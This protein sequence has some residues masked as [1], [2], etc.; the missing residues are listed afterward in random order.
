MSEQIGLFTPAI[1]HKQQALDAIKQFSFPEAK[2][3]LEIAKEIDPYL[4]DLNTLARAVDFLLNL[5]IHQE[6]EPTGLAQAW[7][8]V[9]N[10]RTTQARA[11]NNIMESWLCE[12]IVE[13][14]PQDFCDYVD[15]KQSTLH[16]G[17][18]YLILN[19][20]EEAHK[21]LLNYLT[22]R[23]DEIH[24]RLWGYYGDAAY[25]LNS[26]KDSNSG[27]LRALFMDVQSVDLDSLHHPQIRKIYSELC[28]QHPEE[29]ARALLPINSWFRGI[30]HIP[31]GNTWLSRI[32]QLQRFALAPEMQLS[33]TQRYQQFAL[34][35]Y[36]DQ[37][38]QQGDIDFNARVEMQRL[39]AE[40]FQQY[41]EVVKKLS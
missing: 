10:A 28:R 17:Y 41:L 39:D 11:M 4:A 19:R 27:Y 13:F 34:C 7:E 31:G 6:T 2:N 35:L 8:K 20:P 14:L 38:G 33:P 25:K 32:V 21:K 36:I 1:E 24:P 23:S 12:R 30:L 22:S 29:T 3:H 18:C 15:T 37:S 26:H 9:K 16:I 5:G 40:L